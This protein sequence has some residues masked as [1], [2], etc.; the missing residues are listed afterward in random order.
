MA[1]GDPITP[2]PRTVDLDVD[3]GAPIR[4][5]IQRAL[6]DQ[7]LAARTRIDV[8]AAMVDIVLCV[9]CTGS[10]GPYIK[11]AKDAAER[12][13]LTLRESHGL[14]VR[15][16]FA[17]YRDHPPE[18][19]S[20]AS[21]RF[22]LSAEEDILHRYLCSPDATAQGGGDGPEAVEM[23]LFECLH[24][25]WRTGA[26]K[27]CF[28]IGDAP[29]H[30]LGERK[31]NFPAGS[32]LN[33]DPMCVLD[34]LATQDVRVYALACEP[35]L[36]TIYDTA[37]AFWVA[38]AAKTHGRALAV[39]TPGTLGDIFIGAVLEEVDLT[40]FQEEVVKWI[41][42]ARRWN[43][44]KVDDAEFVKAKAYHLMIQARTMFDELHA[45]DA[46]QLTA[47]VLASSVGLKLAQSKTLVEAREELTP[48]HATEAVSNVAVSMTKA[49][50][51]REQ[52]DRVVNVARAKHRV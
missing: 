45:L 52:F 11:E 3:P 26:T 37:A 47:G 49:T 39:T 42:A 28:L 13:A 30:G 18:E 20:F 41:Q 36:S 22:A 21:R 50:L 15:F 5:G 29:P 48:H 51:T 38:A 33:V 4:V 6:H 14:D 34:E 25:K 16:G 24:M 32:P 27:V 40:C 9:D 31:D 46:H 2:P 23:G 8:A 35:T 17:P 12:V 10:M 19:M 7:L 1:S 43:P 44:D